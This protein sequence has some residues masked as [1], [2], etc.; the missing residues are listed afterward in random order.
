ME[1]QLRYNRERDMWLV[2]NPET[3][4][5][6]QEVENCENVPVFFNCECN[7]RFTYTIHIECKVLGFM[8]T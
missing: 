7:T 5:T 3:G 4:R 2:I 1:I 8:E 6:M